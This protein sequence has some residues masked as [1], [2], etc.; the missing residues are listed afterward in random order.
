MAAVETVP[1][2]ALRYV[3]PIHRKLRGHKADL[4]PE[5]TVKAMGF[6]VLGYNLAAYYRRGAEA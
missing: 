2:K 4:F 5:A 3:K 6:P 1:S